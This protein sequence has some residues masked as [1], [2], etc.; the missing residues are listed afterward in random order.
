[1]PK[2]FE[3]WRLAAIGS[4]VMA[5]AC[6][7]T[8]SGSDKTDS[9]TEI[10]PCQGLSCSIVDCAAK[11]LP[12]TSISGKVFAPNGTLALYGVT[13]YV[14]SSDPGPLRAGVQCDR[15]S[16][17]LQGGA[18]AVATTDE[19]GA[20]K[21]ENVPATANVPLVVQVGKWRRQLTLPNVAAC[22]NL[23]VDEQQTRLPRNQSEGDIPLIAITTGRRDAL[24]CLVRKLGVDD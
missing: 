16:G 5:F 24:E 11:G 22:Q 2:T 12:A 4:L 9:G 23:T 14:P 20:F 1:M 17:E 6:G 19:T 3:N 18:I 15:C 8:P 7:G 10:P 21:I 13:V